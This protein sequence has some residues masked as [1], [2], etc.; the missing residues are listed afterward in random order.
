MKIST[1][2]LKDNRSLSIQPE[3]FECLLPLLLLLLQLLKRPLLLLL[4]LLL[5]LWHCSP[6]HSS[7]AMIV[8]GYNGSVYPCQRCHHDD[9]IEYIILFHATPI[10][11]FLSFAGSRA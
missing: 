10:F 2:L 11:V 6:Y 5:L 1:L 9:C 4:L 7:S 8:Q 3:S